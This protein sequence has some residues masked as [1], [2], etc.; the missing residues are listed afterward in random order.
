LFTGSVI[1]AVEIYD[2]PTNRLLAA[3]VTKQYPGSLNV[4][5]TLGSLAAA[6]TGIEKGADAL[7]AQLSDPENL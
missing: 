2:A 5:A 4:L 6:K 3:F 1:Y 7:L